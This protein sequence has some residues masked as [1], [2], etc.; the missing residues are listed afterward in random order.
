MPKPPLGSETL[1]TVAAQPMAT[2][3]GP[4]SQMAKLQR[5]APHAPPLEILDSGPLLALP[6]RFKRL[7][8][9]IRLVRLPL[10]MLRMPVGKLKPAKPCPTAR[11][12]R[13]CAAPCP[14]MPLQ[15]TAERDP[16][17]T[18][19]LGMLRMPLGK[20]NPAPPLEILDSGP[21]LTLPCRFKRLPHEVRL[22]PLL[23][24]MLRM[25]PGKLNQ[26]HR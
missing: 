15:T 14:S 10:G 6:C 18:L 12:P 26:P 19:L 20:L 4:R 2:H 24:G 17:R 3:L 22:V 21:L 1:C 8:N 13:F 7:P 25:P 5:H 23:L 9:E 11:N 16:P